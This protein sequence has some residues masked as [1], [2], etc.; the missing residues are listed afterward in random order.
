MKSRTHLR[1]GGAADPD[2]VA[3]AG[4]C[5]NAAAVG[6]AGDP[7]HAVVACLERP[8]APDRR[9]DAQNVADVVV[10]MQQKPR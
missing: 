6:V 4:R 10:A 8:P 1:G 9:D 7:D 5:D 3:A 2:Q